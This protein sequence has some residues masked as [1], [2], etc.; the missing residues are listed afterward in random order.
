MGP[1]RSR[2]ARRLVSKRRKMPRKNSR[3]PQKNGNSK[4]RASS[5]FKLVTRT[6]INAIT[7]KIVE[8][9]DPEQVILFGSYAYGKPTID[10]DVDVLVVME[11][12][13]RPA[14]RASRVVGAL[15]DKT[16]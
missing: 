12:T 15:M 1:P 16:F 9:F 10:S 5:P 7:R 14:A 2:W 3:Q 11:S 8:N 4:R 6:Q 13:E